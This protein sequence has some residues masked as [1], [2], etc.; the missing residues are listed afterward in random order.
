[1]QLAVGDDNAAFLEWYYAL[2]HHI[3]ALV[4]E[5]CNAWFGMAC[6]AVEPPIR[7]AFVSN[8]AA[9]D[10]LPVTCLALTVPCRGQQVLASVYDKQGGMMSWRD[11]QC[12]QEVACVV[13]LEGLWFS[14]QRW[15]IRWVLTDV[16]CY[17]VGPPPPAAMLCTLIDDSDDDDDCLY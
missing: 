16:K 6:D 14:N 8:L 17:D 5:R 3:I 12:N 2:E 15:G 13:E 11:V 1:M 7:E 9:D 10:L 4:E